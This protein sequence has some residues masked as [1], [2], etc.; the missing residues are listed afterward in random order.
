M[1]PFAGLLY[2]GTLPL[3]L[4]GGLRHPV[5]GTAW[6]VGSLAVLASFALLGAAAVGADVTRGVQ[7]VA[8]V[9][10]IAVI[11]SEMAIWLGRKT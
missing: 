9:V 6:G 5:V 2:F 3:A 1:L 10:A 7:L 11:A 8:T 4:R